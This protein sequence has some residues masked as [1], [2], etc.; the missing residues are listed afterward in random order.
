MNEKTLSNIHDE[1]SSNELDSLPDVTYA[2][3]YST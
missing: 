1:K 2:V 3:I